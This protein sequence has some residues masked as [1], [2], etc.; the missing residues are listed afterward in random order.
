VYDAGRVLRYGTGHEEDS[1]GG[2]GQASLYDSEEDWSHFEI[3]GAEFERVWTRTASDAS[4]G[5]QCADGGR[6]GRC[7]AQPM[8][9]ASETM[10]PR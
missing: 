10:I 1:Y 7:E 3:T 8:R 4:G 6:C 5:Q 2:L 9:S